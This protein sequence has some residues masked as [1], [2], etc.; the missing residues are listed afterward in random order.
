M[1]EKS[2]HHHHHHHRSYLAV[3][4]HGTCE[5]L[6]PGHFMISGGMERVKRLRANVLE[7]TGQVDRKGE[8]EADVLWG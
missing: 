8:N 3:C 6:C 2:H 1:G 4:P 7:E 5:E